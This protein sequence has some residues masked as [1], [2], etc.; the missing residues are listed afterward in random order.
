MKHRALGIAAGIV[1]AGAVWW[2]AVSS[3]PLPQVLRF[4]SL[5]TVLVWTVVE[6]SRC[7]RKRRELLL[8][9]IVA[10]LIAVAALGS[11]SAGRHY[12]EQELRRREPIFRRVAQQA[13]RD[14]TAQRQE[15]QV[16]PPFPDVRWAVARP[17]PDTGGIVVQFAYR[18]G[19]RSGVVVYVNAQRN[20]EP[21]SQHRC[22]RRVGEDY[23]EYHM[24]K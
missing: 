23:Y 14:V 13:A 6:L 5:L 22:L 19:P 4:L 18:S 1:L 15:V 17:D 24:C 10:L 9:G 12:A 16:T 11:S 20:P 7:R 21:V 2:S 8:S 3:S